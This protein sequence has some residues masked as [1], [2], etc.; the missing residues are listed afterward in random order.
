MSG[1]QR[2]PGLSK[3]WCCGDLGLRKFGSL[4]R[5]L[6]DWGEPPSDENGEKRVYRAANAAAALSSSSLRNSAFSAVKWE[7]PL[8]LKSQASPL[9]PVSWFVPC[10]TA[11]MRIGVG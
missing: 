4:I 1:C 10:S 8:F 3:S 6:S 9:K 7:P 2:C 11:R 5:F